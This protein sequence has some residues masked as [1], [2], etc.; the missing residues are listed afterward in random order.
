M[1][2]ENKNIQCLGCGGW[3]ID[4]GAVFVSV[5]F[6]HNGIEHEGWTCEGCWMRGLQHRG[7]MLNLD[8]PELGVRRLPVRHRR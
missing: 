4:N 8:V 3:S 2:G 1:I 7:R 5:Y 6:I